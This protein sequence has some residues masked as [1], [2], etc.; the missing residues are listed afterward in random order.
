M[1]VYPEDYQVEAS[2]AFT[3]LNG[4]RITPVAVKAVLYDIDEEVIVDFGSLPFDAA[5]SEKTIIVPA[6]FNSLDEGKSRTARILRV[7]LETEAG[8][9]RRSFSYL[10][11]GEFRL[12]FLSNSFL[13][14]E[15]AELLAYDMVNISGWSVAQ[16]DERIAALIEAFARVTRIPL[17][18]PLYDLPSVDFQNYIEYAGINGN[19]EGLNHSQN[20]LQRDYVIMPRHWSEIT[21]KIYSEFPAHFRQALRAAQFCE[22]NELLQGDDTMAKHRAGIVSE[23]IGESSVRLRGG[24]IDLGVSSQTLQHLAGYVHYNFRVAR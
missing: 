13:S 22:A 20:R 6:A 8:V 10:I 3:D 7:E 11:E 1:K 18:F 14:Y 24:R 17:R 15:A 2:F 12:Q 4:D 9:I 19:P 5:A 21:E 16:K 23:T